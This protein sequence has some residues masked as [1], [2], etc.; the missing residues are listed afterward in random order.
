M[1]KSN[2]EEEI[3]RREQEF[4]GRYWIREEDIEKGEEERKK[5]KQ[6]LM[7]DNLQ[8]CKMV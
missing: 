3:E 8:K 5:Q 4:K 1:E 6:K 7:E 2:E